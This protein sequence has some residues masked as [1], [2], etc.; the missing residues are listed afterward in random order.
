MMPLQHKVAIVTGGAVRLGRAIV[1]RLVVQGFR[2]VLHFEHSAAEADQAAQ[3]HGAAVLA[4]QADFRDP[5][6]AAEHLFD[7]ARS[8]FGIVDVL[9]NNAA[10]FEEQTLD[11]VDESAWDRHFSINLKAPFFL[12][13]AFS[14]QQSSAQSAQIVN[15]ADWRGT[16]PGAD[17]L[18]YTLTKSALITMTRSLAQVL[19]PE[20]RVN[21][22][23][24]GA[25]L[26]PPGVEQ[27]VFQQRA[28]ADLLQ[29]PGA[30]QDVLQ[31]LDYLLQSDYVTGDTL[32]V[33]GGQQL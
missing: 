5:V 18:V 21:A 28:A 33:A 4:V 22:I 13:Q 17:H 12:S 9:V 32:H 24:P 19:A 30:P 11:S 7:R 6:A 27:A 14:R 3:E 31:A 8:Q 26:P 29:A 23:A 2:V 16:R 25:I 10:I 20:I 1:D 15:I